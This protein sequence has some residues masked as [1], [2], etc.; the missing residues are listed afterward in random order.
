MSLHSKK[1]APQNKI[2]LKYYPKLIYKKIVD[3]LDFYFQ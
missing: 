1:Y 3:F 2:S